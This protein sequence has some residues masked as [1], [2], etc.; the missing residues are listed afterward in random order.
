[1]IYYILFNISLVTLGCFL[2]WLH[3]GLFVVGLKGYQMIDGK[4]ILALALIGFSVAAFQLLQRRGRF[5]WLYGL[6]GFA[7]LM[8]TALDLYTFYL[9]RYPIGPGIYLVALGGLQLTGAYL[10]LLFN[11]KKGT[12]S[13]F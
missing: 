10:F 9:N 5:D 2:P 1:M 4:V 11:R 13:S 12:A 8:I 6:I 7:I 3:P